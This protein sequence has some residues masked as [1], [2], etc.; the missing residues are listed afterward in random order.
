MAIGQVLSLH[1]AFNLFGFNSPRIAAGSFHSGDFC[2]LSA[3]EELLN[4]KKRA[5]FL[6]FKKINSYP[7]V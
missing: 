1:T 3:G 5:F 6:V 2:F 7:F 4:H